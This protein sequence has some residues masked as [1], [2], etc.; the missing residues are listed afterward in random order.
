MPENVRKSFSAIPIPIPSLYNRRESLRIDPPRAPL[1]F[2]KSRFFIQHFLR[3]QMRPS[4]GGPLSRAPTAQNAIPRQRKTPRR[5]SRR[6]SRAGADATAIDAPGAVTCG[7]DI[8]V[9]ESTSTRRKSE[10]RLSR[11][12]GGRRWRRGDALLTSVESLEGSNLERT[13]I[14][15]FFLR[16]RHPPRTILAVIFPYARLLMNLLFCQR[17]NE[18]C[19]GPQFRADW[20]RLPAM[21]HHPYPSLAPIAYIFFFV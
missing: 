4:R 14:G 3:L 1:R 15:A 8:G 11:F 7:S 9:G 18:F 6:R 16:N 13:I 17:L 5:G 20:C 21:T 19:H 12:P 2:S 10:F